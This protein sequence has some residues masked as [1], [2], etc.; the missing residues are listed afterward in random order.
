M[1][2]KD[3][4]NE[5]N[6]LNP[7]TNIIVCVKDST[8]PEDSLLDFYYKG[9][10]SEIAFDFIDDASAGVYVIEAS[11]TFLETVRKEG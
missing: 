4:I 7:D 5:L 10:I 2:V 1:K 6:T 9:E 3:L 11:N 8:T